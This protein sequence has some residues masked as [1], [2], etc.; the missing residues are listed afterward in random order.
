MKIVRVFFVLILCVG[1][2]VPCKETESGDYEHKI[3]HYVALGD[4]IAKGYGLKDV[5]T[6]SYAGRIMQSLEE[7]YGTVELV[8]F[9]K[10]GLR[11]EQL[12][13]ILVN[14]ENAQHEKYMDAIGK[15]DLITLSIGSNDLLQYLS[16]GIDIK[17]LSENGDEIFT[18]ACVRFQ[19]NIPLIISAIHNQA[20]QAQFF[21]NNIYNPCSDVS[22]ELS[23]KLDTMA[24]KYIA[25]MNE[26]FESA[27]VQSVFSSTNPENGGY[28]QENS[29]V[30]V[31]VKHA[32]EKADE[33]LINMVF[34]WGEIDP[35]PNRE[36]H[37]RIAD[38]IIPR[39]SIQK[40]P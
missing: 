8:N 3:V 16:G 23:E 38:E 5:E 27:A 18:E 11:S 19:E 35:H 1:I 30:L 37:K 4:S 13:D 26:G 17:K 24:E 12:L 39:I 10:N 20:P 29:Y 34:S 21:V 14:E 2:L 9:G 7:R 28:E 6:E 40:E 36:G 22:F 32:F 33:K 25:Q 15:A 31:D